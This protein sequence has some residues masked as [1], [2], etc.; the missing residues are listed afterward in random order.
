MNENA[1]LMENFNKQL[2]DSAVK[3][4]SEKER[5]NPVPKTPYVMK[6]QHECDYFS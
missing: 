2:R 3:H 4:I 6:F 1:Q 5:K